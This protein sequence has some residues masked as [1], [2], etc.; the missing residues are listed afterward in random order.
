MNLPAPGKGCL[1][2]GRPAK[3]AS[4]VSEWH[5]IEKDEKILRAE[6][7]RKHQAFSAADLLST[8]RGDASLL[9]Y[10][11]CCITLFFNPVVFSKS[12]HQQIVRN[13]IGLV[14]INSLHRFRSYQ[15]I[16][17]CF[18]YCLYCCFK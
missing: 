1:A 15:S 4:K 3:S 12:L 5:C 17:D 10:S 16:Y 9:I 14:S 11:A 13:C 7:R 6:F 18:F 2:R 8:Q